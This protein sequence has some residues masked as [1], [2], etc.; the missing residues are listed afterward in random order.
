M[1]YPF[2]ELQTF[3]ESITED[4]EKGIDGHNFWNEAAQN[5]R[6][7]VLKEYNVSSIEELPVAYSGL[8]LAE[9][10]KYESEIYTK[11]FNLLQNQYQKQLNVYRVFGMLSPTLPVRF[12]SMALTRSDYGFLWHFEDQA[13]K[14]RLEL[15][16]ALNMDI[17]GN[18]KG[19]SHYKAKNTLWSSIPKFK[20]DWQPSEQVFHDHIPEYLIL[21]FWTM[22]SFL[23]MLFSTRTIK[24]V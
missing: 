14:Y 3:T 19:V 17:A 9:G 2:P 15:N 20:Y 13:E 24:V 12:S 6:Q 10:E 18:A 21:I 5:F 23:V 1:L 11:H 8:L 4:K 7:K 22:G 16:T